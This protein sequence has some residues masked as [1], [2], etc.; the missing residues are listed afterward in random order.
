MYRAVTTYFLEHH[1]AITNPREIGRALANIKVTFSITS[2][3][4]TE[5]YLNGIN[6]EREIRSMRVSEWVSQV[7][8]LKEVREAMVQAQRKLG[9]SKGIVMDGRDIGTVV[10][11]H[12][13]VKV[14]L[15]ADLPVRAFRR[16]RELLEKDELVDL[17]TIMENLRQR[18]AYDSSRKISPLRKAE[19]AIVLD[20]T[21]ITIDEQ[22]DEVIRLAISRMNTLLPPVERKHFAKKK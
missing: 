15:T 11:P 5:T 9:K 8:A 3:G 18:D 20:T 14:F 4:V 16:Q 19:D 13:E 17:D 21:Q 6:V 1:V 12:A 22:V 10:F 2:Q 7:S